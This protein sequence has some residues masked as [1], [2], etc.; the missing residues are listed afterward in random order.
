MLASQYSTAQVVMNCSCTWHRPSAS[1]PC[2]STSLRFLDTCTA[3][4]HTPLS[5]HQQSLS[6][7]SDAQVL[8][9]SRNDPVH[10]WA[11]EHHNE[12]RR[13]GANEGKGG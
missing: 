5:Y 8:Q 10:K 6:T 13:Q 4:S 7:I 9:P 1:A 12:Q 3:G 2:A 11:V